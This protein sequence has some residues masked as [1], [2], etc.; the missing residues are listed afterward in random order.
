MDWHDSGMTV[1]RGGVLR[2]VGWALLAFGVL[3][4]CGWVVVQAVRTR[5]LPAQFQQW[6]NWSNI[7]AMLLSGLGTALV[8]AD[9]A[10]PRKTAEQGA[11]PAAP[12]VRRFG[13]IPQLVQH[14][15]PRQAE[16]K[17]LS[18]LLKGRSRAALVALP[19]QR[20]A[21]K[22]QL[23]AAYA[24]KCA[25]D[26]FDLVAWVN[27]ESGPVAGLARLA[28]ELGLG[29]GAA[30]SPED[31]ARRVCSWL[32][33]QD[34]AR[35]LLVFDNVEDPDAVTPYLP[36]GGATK[37]IV[38]TNRREF[39]AVAGFQVVP[40]GM[41]TREQ[42][43]TYLHKVTG[44]AG[45]AG[46][47]ELGVELGWLP[48]G[49]AQAGAYI[50]ANLMSYRQYLKAL[51]GQD[52]DE[53]LRQDAGTDHP[54]VLKATSLSVEGLSRDDPS[55]DAARLL[56]VLAVLSPDGVSRALLDHAH[57]ALGLAG[58]LGNALR[59][60]AAASLITL[61]GTAED[62]YGRDAVV[63]A[64]HRLT[65]RVIRHH[66]T[67]PDAPLPLADAIEVATGLLDQLTDHFPYEQVAHRRA[68]L[69]ELVAHIQTLRGHTTDPQPLLLAQ[70]DWAGRAL[71]EAG[72][73][74]RAVP[75][76][77]ATF[78]VRQRVLGDDHPDTL[79]SRN[80]LA[81]TYESAG[82]L[83][84]AIDLYE[85]ILTDR[86]RV[87]GDDHPDTLASR[88]NL[89]GAYESAGRLDEAIDL[90]EQT[91]TDCERVLGDDHP[92]TLTSR[93]NLAY[94]YE[95]AGRLDEA[96]DLY[97][98]TLTD[99]RRVL[100]DDHPDTLAS[101]NNLAGAYESAGRLDEAIDLYEQTLTDRRRVLGD[102]HPQTLTSRNNLAS[103]YESAG[104]L[105]DAIDLYEQTL[106][107]SKR[108][109]GDDHP[110]TLTSR[111]NL[112]SAY[113]SAG[114]LNEAIPLHEQLFTDRRRVLGD[115]HPDTL[116]SRNNLAYT[117][118]SAGRLNEAIPLHEQLFTDRRR[119]LG[120]DHPDTLTSR[121]NLAYT[122]AS[123]GRLNE[124]ID[125]FE[126]LFTD[127]RRVLGDDHPDTIGVR[128]N[129]AAARRAQEGQ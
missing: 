22:S 98:Q 16:A 90:Y 120:D 60:L 1:R 127:R 6:T 96:I 9:K 34:R 89:A 3:L 103:A 28:T 41:F 115:D 12:R 102:D 93:N 59:V 50:A 58:D 104:R 108:V 70:T 63:V 17:T 37:V 111:N 66:A 46:A 105:N 55:G 112:A 78:T 4:V 33:N 53:I 86:R 15:Q 72:D 18:G 32:Q 31:R 35:R 23:A 71:R 45:G 107:D 39:A 30:E 40:V 64:V 83:D 113:A 82:R 49:L 119:V 51:A 79:T 74:T 92:D 91:L 95:S 38:T 61:N 84:E 36:S 68:E 29:G 20:G 54:G 80:N 76:L 106:T 14:F 101:R 5:G 126:Q 129:L 100:G 121:N 56:T 123:A 65:A 44:L 21:G 8:I 99:R 52:L 42:G 81:Y 73:L 13:A 124:A 125:L 75:L 2:R 62:Q 122:Y 94:T 47:D 114:R 19:G 24:W 87:L 88:N 77:E 128:E 25:E 116:T 69:D 43:Q 67:K 117:Y 26:G 85:Q 27:A 118:A 110:D 109:L 48:L 57:P 97:E 10:L 7:I 11:S